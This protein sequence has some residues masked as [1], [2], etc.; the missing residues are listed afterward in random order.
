MRAFVRRVVVIPVAF[1]VALGAAVSY[2]DGPA[3]TASAS[4]IVDPI[5]VAER[6]VAQ[7]VATLTAGRDC[8]TD[9]PAGVSPTH[10]V[11]KV[12]GTTTVR[13]VTADAAWAQASAGDV[14]VLAWCAEEGR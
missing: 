14:W 13:L 10:A 9:V 8:T 7:R 12:D 1:G 3:P 2:F 5:V 6:T 11:V 4:P